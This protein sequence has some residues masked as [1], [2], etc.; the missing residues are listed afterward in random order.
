MMA[1]RVQAVP[2]ATVY[3]LRHA[4][5]RPNQR[6][7]ECFFPGDNDPD[8]VHFAAILDKAV[9]GIASICRQPPP[10][11]DPADAWRLRGMATEPSMRG[12]GIGSALLQA[13]I[14]HVV[15]KGGEL[16]WCNARTPA[17]KFYERYGFYCIGE[18]FEMPGIGP[19]YLMMKRLEGSLDG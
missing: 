8:T 4:V 5:L 18:E 1:V 14:A 11:G 17:V 3:P 15:S 9:I 12:T 10:S 13:C 7:E 2:A 19:H 16:I 6:P